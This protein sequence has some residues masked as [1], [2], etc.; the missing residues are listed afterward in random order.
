MFYSVSVTFLLQ[1]GRIG[2]MGEIYVFLL[3]GQ[4]PSRE[5]ILGLELPSWLFSEIRAD[6]ST[7]TGP[8]VTAR[9]WFS[10]EALTHK[11]CLDLSVLTL[12]V[13]TV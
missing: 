4:W 5:F 12:S 11:L 8:E 10:W 6:T 1:V 9:M 7:P 13:A 2:G 3:N